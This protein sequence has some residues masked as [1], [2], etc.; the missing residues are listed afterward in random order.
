MTWEGQVAAQH[1]R[2][3]R[4]ETTLGQ[5]KGQK[6]NMV[7]DKLMQNF[8]IWTSSIMQRLQALLYVYPV[9]LCMEML[10]FYLII[11]HTYR[12]DKKFLRFNVKKY[13]Y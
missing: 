2:A 6:N 11:D 9:I 10:L 12:E 13:I 4:A 5:T 8:Q 7:K 3:T 1:E